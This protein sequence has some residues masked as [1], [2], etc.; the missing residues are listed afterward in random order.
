M[1]SKSLILLLLLVATLS[2]TSSAFL[3]RFKAC[4]AREIV[5]GMDQYCAPRGRKD[6]KS[7]MHISPI[8][9]MISSD[10]EEDLDFVVEQILKSSIPSS[11][12][13]IQRRYKRDEESL[14]GATMEVCCHET[15]F[16]RRENVTP[17][18]E[19]LKQLAQKMQSESS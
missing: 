1:E 19:Y 14:E 13:R 12:M 15:C 9:S 16:I 10:P 4:E 7:D 11:K 6:S 8:G 5:T 2:S 3:I 18:C 17:N